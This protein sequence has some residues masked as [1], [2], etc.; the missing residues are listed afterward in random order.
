MHISRKLSESSENTDKYVEGAELS[1]GQ[2]CE[3]FD[4]TYKVNQKPNE[5]RENYYCGITNN[6]AHNKS[7]HGVSHLICVKCKDADTAAGVETMLRD[8]GFNIGE[9][10]YEGNGGADDS[11]F[12]YMCHKTEDFKN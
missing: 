5:T 2:I 7:R 1:N 12:V 6:I 9:P 4:H 8:M 10:R 11:I 3:L